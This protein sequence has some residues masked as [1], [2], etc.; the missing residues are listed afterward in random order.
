M[1]A[2][3][4]SEVFR[5]RGFQEAADG[6]RRHGIIAADVAA[7]LSGKKLGAAYL[8]GLGVGLWKSV[9][10][11]ESHRSVDRVFEPS[12]DAGERER[13]VRWWRKAVDRTKDWAEDES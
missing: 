2:C 5:V 13:L 11:L 12:M 4:Y 10:E 9:D 8:A 6:V 3:L 7:W 1:S